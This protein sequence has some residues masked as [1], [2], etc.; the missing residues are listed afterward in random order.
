MKKILLNVYGAEIRVY[1][2]PDE[3]ADNLSEY[4]YKFFDWMKTSPEA[5]NYRENGVLHY[6]EDDFILYLNK[7]VFKNAKSKFIKA[8]SGIYDI[9]EIYPK[10]KEYSHFCF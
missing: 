3:V 6:D 4:C 10:Y 8:L 5:K 7:F 1:S 9:S 2:V